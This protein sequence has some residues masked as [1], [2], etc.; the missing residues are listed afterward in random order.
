[1]SSPL[2]PLVRGEGSQ[3][4]G[5]GACGAVRCSGQL[6]VATAPEGGGH[7]TG[8][9]WVERPR[10]RCPVDQCGEHSYALERMLLSI[11]VSVGCVVH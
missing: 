10:R 8:R 4:S 11:A 2:A 1:M 3:S 9:R 5:R 7:E 6:A